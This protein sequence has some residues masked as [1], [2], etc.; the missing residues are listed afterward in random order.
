MFAAR[1][2]PRS[3][4][5]KIAARSPEH[6]A[7]KAVIWI[8]EMVLNPP[9]HELNQQFDRRRKLLEDERIN[10][11]L[12]QHGIKRPILVAH[13]LQPVIVASRC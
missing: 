7:L 3:L 1:F 5:S 13:A 10:L 12:Y 4:V 11:V 6:F 8:S 2:T 9:M